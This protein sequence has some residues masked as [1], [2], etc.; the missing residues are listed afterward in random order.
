MRRIG[1]TG[2]SF[3]VPSF[4]ERVTTSPRRPEMTTMS[5]TASRSRWLALYVPAWVT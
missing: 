3:R 1:W 4:V 2:L 5:E